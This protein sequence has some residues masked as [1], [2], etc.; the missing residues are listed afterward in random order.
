MEEIR[1]HKHHVLIVGGGFGGIKAA[2]EL[3]KQPG[4]AVTIL[5]DQPDFRYYPTLYHT[6]TGGLR[7]QSSI[8]LRDILPED[9]VT[10]AHGTAKTL[11]R[12]HQKIHT[13]EG[14]VIP[15]D[16]LILALGSVTNYFGIK[17]LEQ[18]AYGIKSSSEALRF[19]KHLHDQL[20]A[21][22]APDLN[23]IIV[24][25]GPTGIELAGSLPH[26]IRWMM[27]KHG[28]K[29]RAVH[30]D[31][32][33]AAPRLLPRSPKTTSRAVRRRLRNLKVRL[34]LGEAVQGETADSLMVSGKPML[35]HTVVWTAGTAINH[36]FADNNFAMS[37]HHRVNVDSFLRAEPHIYVLGDNA[38]T[39]YSGMAQTAL[40]DAVFVVKNLVR[41]WHNKQPIPYKPKQ[42]ATV[43]PVGPY[44]ATV[45]WGLL[46]VSGLVG[47][48]LREAADWVGFHDYL[49]WW[50]A[51]E[52]WATEF[53]E[54]ESCKIC[55]K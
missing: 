52:Q 47:W 15:Y 49:P 40:Y 26:Y 45:D 12:D 38:S 23:Y 29:R 27:K 50:K 44:W 33:E 20:T 48:L 14:H 32:I 19:K 24:G 22:H 1:Y 42:P 6:A 7:S 55:R 10:I 36:F 5:S 39:P 17:G 28:I 37:E 3:S 46:H 21:D 43:I 4:V 16:T 35:S 8:R 25:G 31:L 11:D 18:Y 9:K 2:L 54:E 30:I 13:K 53:A 41:T 51:T 34:Y